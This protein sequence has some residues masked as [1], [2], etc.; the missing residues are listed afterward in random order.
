MDLEDIQC[1]QCSRMFAS[2]GDLIP[3]LIPENGYTYCTSCLQDMLNISKGQPE[4]F[5]PDDSE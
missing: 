3:R 2:T 5:C 4:F 1:G